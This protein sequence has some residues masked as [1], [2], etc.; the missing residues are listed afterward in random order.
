MQFIPDERAGPQDGRVA[1]RHTRRQQHRPA[2][3]GRRQGFIH[4]PPGG[5]EDQ[6]ARA[7]GRRISSTSGTVHMNRIPSR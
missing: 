3:E 2:P 7:R 1:A 5:L 6:I 4:G